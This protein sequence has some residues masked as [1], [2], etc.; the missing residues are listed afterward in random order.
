MNI[1]AALDQTLPSIPWVIFATVIL[2]IYRRP[3]GA[4]LGRIEK[5]ATPFG[6]VHLIRRDLA[7][8]TMKKQEGTAHHSLEGVIALLDTTGSLL[9]GAAI[10][11]VDDN[12]LN[13]THERAALR[14]CG[15]HIDMATTT[16]KARA[17][18]TRECYDLIISDIGRQNEGTTGLDFLHLLRAKGDIT[19]LVFYVGKVDGPV[20]R[21]SSGIVD[22]PN[23]LMHLVLQVLAR[24]S[25]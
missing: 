23:D 5:F 14:R 11:W 15:A 10:L 3:I 25:A 9:R 7:I 4:L 21:G 18:M 24:V 6:D 13:N 2:V 12:P 8:A 16:A 19:P 1:T 17:Y 20:P 22:M